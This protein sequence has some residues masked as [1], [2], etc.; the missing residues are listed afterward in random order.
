MC[1]R[2]SKPVV[3]GWN[4]LRDR[5]YLDVLG[6][7]DGTRVSHWFLSGDVIF[8]NMFPSF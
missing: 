4:F 1:Y 5:A 2:S 6:K 7:D 3:T 8:S